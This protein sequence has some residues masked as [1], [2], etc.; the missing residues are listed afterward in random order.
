MNDQAKQ[1]GLIYQKIPQ[2]MK[3]IQA[4]GKNGTNQKQG[5]SFRKIEDVCNACHVHLRDAEIF[6]SPEVIES[7]R[8]ERKTK[9]GGALIYSLLKVRHTFY[10]TDGSF[11]TCTTVG[12]G[13]DSGDKASNKAMSA[14][15]KY[16]LMELFCIPTA[17]VDS[18]GD[19]PQ[20]MPQ[21]H[22]QA[23][24]PAPQQATQP[25]PQPQ[26]AAA[27]PPAAAPPTQP[28]V[29]T[30][31]PPQVNTTSALDAKLAEI[32]RLCDAAALVQ[33]VQPNAILK[34]A[35]ANTSSDWPGWGSTEGIRKCRTPEKSA[36][37]AL[38]DVNRYTANILQ[39]EAAGSDAREPVYTPAPET[40]YVDDDMPF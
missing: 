33:N 34:A 6:C 36:G 2:V 22:T 20:P 24:A 23:P 11:V 39:G 7:T 38:K 12:E 32:N 4:V 10:A 37:F 28:P 13:M 26:Q 35:T 9:S 14:A 16:A 15:F 1:G 19:S 18:E 17:D 30:A 25:A 31:Q 5:Y 21:G 8:E 40:T 27:P 3:S 29:E